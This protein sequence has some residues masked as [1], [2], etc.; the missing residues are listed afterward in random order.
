MQLINAQLGKQFSNEINNEKRDSYSFNNL[1]FMIQVQ[2]RC[3]NKTKTSK[4]YV[5]GSRKKCFPPYA[6]DPLWV[7]RHLTKNQRHCLMCHAK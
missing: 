1:H 2:N 3:A 4:I 5:G 7:D 6:V